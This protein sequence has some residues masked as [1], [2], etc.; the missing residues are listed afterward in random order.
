MNIRQLKTFM[1]IAEKGTFSAAGEAV[2]LSHSAVSL[3]VKALEQSLDIALVDRSRRPPALTDTG[4]ALVERIRRMIDLLDDISSLG[5]QRELV[6]SISVGVVPS[7]MVDLFPPALAAI[8]RQH[9]MLNVRI[10]TGLSG[11]LALLVRSGD[12]DVAIATAPRETLDGLRARTILREP[13]Y[14]IAHV[15][16]PEESVAELVQAHPFILFSR[17]TWAGQQIETM[18]YNEKISINSNMEINSIPAIRALVEHGLGVSII[19]ERPGIVPASPQLRALPFG[20]PQHAR[21]LAQLERPNNPKSRLA[22]AL[23]AALS[24]QVAVWTPPTH[25]PPPGKALAAGL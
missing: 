3:H 22:D 15:D 25:A 14:A 19:P 24:D 23:F 7:A 18:L 11:E 10:R 5:S 2:G 17:Q 20:A 21:E 12:M 6:G 9:P 13:L 4:H 1:A 8:A 16:F